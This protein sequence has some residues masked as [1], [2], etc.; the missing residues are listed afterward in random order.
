MSRG[1]GSR[2][3]SQCSAAVAALAAEAGAN[4]SGRPL[5]IG[6]GGSCNDGM[7]GEV[8]IGCSA[9]SGGN[10]TAH[11]KT[12][13]DTG[14]DCISEVY[15]LVCSGKQRV[16]GIPIDHVHG[17]GRR[18]WI[19]RQGQA[20]RNYEPDNAGWLP[21]S[22]PENVG[23]SPATNAIFTKWK[24]GESVFPTF[25]FTKQWFMHLEE[26]NHCFMHCFGVETLSGTLLAPPLK[27]F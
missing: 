22:F 26:H 12:T 5:Q 9:Q 7:W 3:E 13:G 16:Y 27:N 8:P 25:L 1:Y 2:S 23:P 15:Q 4:V 21:L 24:A 6:S 10:W 19:K 14:Q 20:E 17:M 18:R 11:Y